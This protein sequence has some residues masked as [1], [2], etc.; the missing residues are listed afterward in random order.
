MH[1][2]API[3]WTDSALFSQLRPRKDYAFGSVSMSCLVAGGERDD[4]PRSTDSVAGD[5]CTNVGLFAERQ[6]EG[7][8]VW[9]LG[10]KLGNG[11]GRS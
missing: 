10:R 9:T 11:V 8:S 6:P 1:Y 4:G 7:S 2:E 3:H 5:S